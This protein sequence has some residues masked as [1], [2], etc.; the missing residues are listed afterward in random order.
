MRVGANMGRESLARDTPWD[1][2]LILKL[3]SGTFIDIEYISD[4]S[5]DINVDI[6]YIFYY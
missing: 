2:L 1:K 5:I 6:R 4:T 3:I